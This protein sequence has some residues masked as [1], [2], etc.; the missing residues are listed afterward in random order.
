MAGSNSAGEK[1]PEPGAASVEQMAESTHQTV[2]ERIDQKPAG[3]ASGGQSKNQPMTASP[4]REGRLTNQRSKKG[5]F[6]DRSLQTRIGSVLRDS[7]ADIEKEALPERLQ[8]LIKALQA[9]EQG[10]R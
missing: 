5:A 2:T 10:R 8:D 6:L 1:Q 9:R 3:D 4:V 7:F